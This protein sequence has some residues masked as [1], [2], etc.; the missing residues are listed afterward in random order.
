MGGGLD[1]FRLPAG[2]ATR[3]LARR[4]VDETPSVPPDS[5][6]PR[7][8]PRNM[9]RHGVLTLPSPMAVRCLACVCL[10]GA[11]VSA[12]GQIPIHQTPQQSMPGD[13][14][15]AS[16]VGAPASPGTTLFRGRS[17]AYQV[18]D[19]LAIYDGDIIIGPAEEVAASPEG[20]ASP[21]STSIPWFERREVSAIEGEN[22]LW[23][24]GRIP[25]AIDPSV[26]G[27]REDLDRAIDLW[28]SETVITL[29]PRTTER[30]YVRFSA[31]SRGCRAH[32]GRV[33]G[34]QVTTIGNCAYFGILHEIGH[35]V[36]LYHPHAR[37]DRDE[38]IMFEPGSEQE[39][40]V[41]PASGPYDYRSN[42]HW[43]YEYFETIPPG[44]PYASYLSPGDIDGV[45]RL[46]G[47]PPTATT[48]S[49]N[50]AGLEVIVDGERVTAPATFEWAPGST[51]VLEVPL[52]PQKSATEGPW[53]SLETR[54]NAHYVFGRWS[55]GGSRRHTV[56]A[57]SGTTWYQASFVEIAQPVVRL[58]AFRNSQWVD[59]RGEALVSV[60]PEVG[61]IRALQNSPDGFLVRGTPITLEARPAPG[62]S[63]LLG[64]WWSG[65]DYAYLSKSARQVVRTLRA[66]S[67]VPYFSKG[68][69]LSIESNAPTVPTFL[70]D[71]SRNR[72]FTLWAPVELDPNVFGT[73]AILELAARE[74][75]EHEGTRFRFENWGDGGDDERVELGASNPATAYW[76]RSRRL[77]FPSDGGAL[78]LNYS[79]KHLLSA[80]VSPH[81]SGH[82]VVV[83]PQSEDG[84]YDSG[85]L[86]QVTASPSRDFLRWEGDASGTATQAIVVMDRPKTVQAVFSSNS[87]DAGQLAPRLLAYP[88]AFTFVTHEGSDSDPQIVQITNE[89][90]EPL[91]FQA[92]SSRD[93]MSVEPTD[94]TLHG[95][96]TQEITIRASSAKLGSGARSAEI[97]I[98]A[99]LAQS[100]GARRR[101]VAIPVHHV[102]LRT[103]SQSVDLTGDASVTVTQYWDGLW[104]IGSNVVESGYRHVDGGKEYVLKQVEGRWKQMTGDAT[105]VLGAS[106]Q[107]VVV[108]VFADKTSYL[109]GELVAPGRE[110]QVTAANGDTYAVTREV[111]GTI[112]ATYVPRSHTVLMDDGTEITLTKAWEGKGVEK[113]RAGPDRLRI[114]RPIVQD[115]KEYFLELVDSQWRSAQYLVRTVVGD[116]EVSDG[117]PALEA[118]LNVPVGVAVDTAG[119]VFVTDAGS[120]V[121]R[122]IDPMGM[123]ATVAGTGWSGY[124]GDG[125]QAVEANLGRP[126]AVDADVWGNVYVESQGR[127]RKIDATG[128]ITTVAGTGESG[129]SGDGGPATEARLGPWFDIA[130]DYAG[131]VYV[132]DPENNRVRR[133]QATGKITTVAGTGEPGYSG[134][135]GQATEAQIRRPRTIVADRAGNVYFANNWRLRRIDAAGMITTVAGDGG[136]AS[137]EGVDS[138]Y[139]ID[140]D[141]V[142]NIFIAD[143][144]YE[145]VMKIDVSGEVTTVAR[146][147]EIDTPSDVAVDAAGNVYITEPYEDRL[148]RIDAA[149]KIHA[150]AGTDGWTD[151]DGDRVASSIDQK[152]K[153]PTHVAV[154]LVGEVFFVDRRRIWKLDSAAGQVSAFAG[155]GKAGYSGD[156]GN[157]GPATEAQLGLIGGVATDG[158]GNVYVADSGNHAVRKIDVTGTITRVAGTGAYG[159][160]G[161]GGP[162]TEAQLFSPSSLASDGLGSLYMVDQR[163]RRI[164]KIDPAGTITAVAVSEFDL[165]GVAVDTSGIVYVH[166]AHDLHRIDASGTIRKIRYFPADIAA[167]A[168]DDAGDVIVG[169]EDRIVKLNARTL[170]E[171]VLAG[172]GDGNFKGNRVPGRSALLS[173]ARQ[174][175]AVD[176]DGKVWFAD[177]EN[178]RIRVV[179]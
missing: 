82:S 35:N 51:H 158:S 93:W 34:E 153:D 91:S 119:N 52:N 65:Q 87:H 33:G 58:R 85:T 131:N 8:R 102:T 154:G 90:N 113:W 115:G 16:R 79:K 130:A 114:D 63:Y 136:P 9:F 69:F 101:S 140:L 116:S 179:E 144:L 88:R 121:V 120:H 159:F 148:Q 22:R 31:Q 111:N 146:R 112:S 163:Y 19:G 30:D 150:F 28:N 78:Q 60:L 41:T 5:R 53:W 4:R 174:G 89:T 38:H 128:T 42:M 104:R 14:L 29:V 48:I 173:V 122:R 97:S 92:N 134:D 133:I 56:T 94:G 7:H 57:D 11:W 169:L 123:I 44:M 138:I 24:G 143:S 13:H 62:T 23:P 25:F 103:Q 165:L 107:S 80:L 6:V 145:R 151:P 76:A 108:D 36:G 109:D 50:P 81:S 126:R 74:T 66:D 83:S 168:I 71:L 17:V 40:A 124:S 175:I 167:I 64:L 61:E 77:E 3:L 177:A 118:S 141:A 105:V 59:S 117:T 161:D 129:Y 70:R 1:I 55:D 10:F 20:S 106:G 164:R 39:Q 46:Y 67:V 155:T 172:P 49:T 2:Y 147:P 15:F 98:V 100:T 157:G 27:E 86:V 160:S 178:R 110:V 135:G 142:G 72:G 73:D 26:D 37:V 43:P 149:G 84:Y 75:F 132:A 125:G 96:E 166:S 18:V 68:P 156:S 137:A 170:E 21:K 45:A 139:R 32:V 152:L 171:S 54:R 47:R 176:K 99:A 95:L 127:V 162:A 12:T